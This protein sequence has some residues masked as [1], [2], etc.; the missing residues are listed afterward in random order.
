MEKSKLKRKKEII[1]ERRNKGKPG[2]EG[3]RNK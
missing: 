1:R 3:G 2:R